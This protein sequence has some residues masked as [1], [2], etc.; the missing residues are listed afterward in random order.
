M[1]ETT[2]GKINEIFPCVKIIQMYGLSELGGLY[3]QFKSN[4]S[5]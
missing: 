2:L 5:L 1:L 4:D 3:S